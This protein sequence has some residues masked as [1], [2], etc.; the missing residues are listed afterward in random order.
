[1]EEEI[2]KVK[3]ITSCRPPTFSNI[4]IRHW[5][6]EITIIRERPVGFR[7]KVYGE[8]WQGKRLVRKWIQYK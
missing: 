6:G 2:H 7:I 5:G 1:M 4:T 3:K 8:T